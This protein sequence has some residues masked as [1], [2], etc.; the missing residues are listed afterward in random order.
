MGQ[1]EDGPHSS[2]SRR[3]GHS[4]RFWA[5]DASGFAASGIAHTSGERAHSPSH[6]A[7]SGP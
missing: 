7:R 4:G 5:Y 1:T 2:I 3:W 6:L